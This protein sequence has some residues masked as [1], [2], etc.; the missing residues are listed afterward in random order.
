MNADNF[1]LDSEWWTLDDVFNRLS[2]FQTGEFISDMDPNVIAR[3]EKCHSYLAS[4]IAEKGETIYG[5]NTGF[6]SLAHTKIAPDKL[7]EL[8]DN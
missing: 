8:Q 3:V 6:G 4:R 7:S 1:M 2:N 5:V